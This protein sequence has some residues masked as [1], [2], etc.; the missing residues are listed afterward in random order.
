MDRVKKGQG[1]RR[2]FQ[3][4]S[5]EPLYVG[6]WG[7]GEEVG[8]GSRNNGKPLEGFKRERLEMN[9]KDGECSLAPSSE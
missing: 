1:D 2:G 5:R 6:C 4:S 3:R 9:G 8:F 7:P